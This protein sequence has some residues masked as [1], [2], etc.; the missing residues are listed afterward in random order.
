VLRPVKGTNNLVLIL[1]I[2]VRYGMWYSKGTGVVAYCLFPLRF[3]ANCHVTYYISHIYMYI[4][5][6]ACLS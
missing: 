6:L 2:Y 4:L 5:A 1:L 3:P